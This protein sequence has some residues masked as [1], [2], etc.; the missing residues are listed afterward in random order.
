MGCSPDAREPIPKSRSVCQRQNG[1]IA[2]ELTVMSRSAP[3]KSRAPG[4]GRG[5]S[6]IQSSRSDPGARRQS[7][8]LRAAPVMFHR[9]A[10][11][12]PREGRVGRGR[13][14]KHGSR[15]PG[16]GGAHLAPHILRV[17]VHRARSTRR[18]F[19][20][21]GAAPVSRPCRRDTPQFTCQPARQR[22]SPQAIAGV[23]TA[24]ENQRTVVRKSRSMRTIW[25]TVSRGGADQSRA[26]APITKIA[27][28]WLSLANA[29]VVPPHDR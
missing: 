28:R 23:R 19:A 5:L 8:P 22:Q 25:L 7:D 10:P 16:G 18:P 29:I 4:L 9:W 12:H 24:G 17:V 21:G 13:I 3:S 6:R 11:F 27:P 14:G 20:G 26:D 1:K 15:D 2:F